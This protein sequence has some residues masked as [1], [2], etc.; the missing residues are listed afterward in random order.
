MLGEANRDPI[1]P[2]VTS[3]HPQFEMLGWTWPDMAAWLDRLSMGLHA[4]VKLL[5]ACLSRN[6]KYILI[7]TYHT[8]S[9][10]YNSIAISCNML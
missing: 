8:M 6:A 1:C 4:S 2:E 3:G 7:E 5:A 10:K 9:N